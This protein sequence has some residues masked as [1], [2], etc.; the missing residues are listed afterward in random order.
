MSNFR[1]G[2]AGPVVG[3]VSVPEGPAG[4]YFLGDARPHRPSE[5]FGFEVQPW[6]LKR[7]GRHIPNGKQP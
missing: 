2:E 3:A 7:D 5:F 4:H 6:S 1:L